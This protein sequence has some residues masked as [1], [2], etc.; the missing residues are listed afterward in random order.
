MTTTD[1]PR[2]GRPP[3]NGQV[4]ADQATANNAAALLENMDNADL[5]ALLQQALGV[6][7]KAAEKPLLQREQHNDQTYIHETQMPDGRKLRRVIPPLPRLP[8]LR[9]VREAR[10]LTQ[11]QLAEAA[12]VD[13][14]TVSRLE[15]QRN[16]ARAPTMNRL[17]RS[18]GVDPRVLTKYEPGQG[19][20]GDGTDEIQD[21]DIGPMVPPSEARTG[22]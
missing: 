5:L 7:V 11:V 13:P 8:G 20:K 19:K 21:G 9:Y 2:R 6:N 12:S 16:P 15:N 17:A 3:K 4:P 14:L 10:A 18:L 22:Y 1:A